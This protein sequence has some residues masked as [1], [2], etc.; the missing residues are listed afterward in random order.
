MDPWLRNTGPGRVVFALTHSVVMVDMVKILHMLDT[1]KIF[2][3]VNSSSCL[4]FHAK[5]RKSDF[6]KKEVTLNEFTLKSSSRY[7]CQI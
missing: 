3:Q 4:V 1:S 2:G 5:C 6:F 7:F